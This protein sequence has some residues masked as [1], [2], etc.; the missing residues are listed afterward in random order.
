MSK[1]QDNLPNQHN[2]RAKN[3]ATANVVANMFAEIDKY[4]S[5]EEL[6]AKAHEL[7]AVGA[8][9]LTP[10]QQLQAAIKDI[11]TN[12]AQSYQLDLDDKVANLARS[13]S[14]DKEKTA[15]LRKAINRAPLEA[16]VTNAA[17]KVVLYH[18]LLEEP[19]AG[20]AISGVL[21]EYVTKYSEKGV[22][23]LSDDIFKIASP[24]INKENPLE[25]KGLKDASARI[26]DAY[27]SKN[28]FIESVGKIWR[29]FVDSLPSIRATT[30]EMDKV[31]KHYVTDQA[32]ATPPKV[33]SSERGR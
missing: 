15:S 20:K 33:P 16:G 13:F 5:P 19:E 17:V 6:N 7:D 23:K 24:V 31:V 21:S 3:G 10:K 4:G 18:H 27:K 22:V 9:M 30:K 28:T 25:V 32:P 8:V 1:D 2:E 14:L 11:D 29:S 26:V 12:G